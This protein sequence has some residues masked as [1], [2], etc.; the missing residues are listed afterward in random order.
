MANQF[1]V[2]QVVDPEDLFFRDAFISEL[3]NTLQRQHV[4]LTAPRRSGKPA[5]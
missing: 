3:W 2:G 1:Y 4:I 5:S